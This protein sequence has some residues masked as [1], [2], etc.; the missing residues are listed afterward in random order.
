MKRLI[1]TKFLQM[2]DL[3]NQTI[4]LL[5]QAIE[6][7][8]GVKIQYGDNADMYTVFPFEFGSSKDGNITIKTYTTDGAVKQYTVEKIKKILPTSEQSTK[9]KYN[10]HIVPAD[11]YATMQYE[12]DK[13]AKK[14]LESKNA[15]DI[16]T[17][18]KK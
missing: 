15:T 9:D 17:T 1:S 18:I 14:Q 4:Q 11:E 12:L 5:D 7:Q 16:I 3:N 2:K 13:T 10:E 6:Y 8:T